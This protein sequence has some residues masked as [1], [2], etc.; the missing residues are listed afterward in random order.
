[1]Y[2]VQ[3]NT[4][5][6]AR[7]VAMAV[8]R[9]AWWRSDRAV[10][11]RRVRRRCG[12]M[13][14]MSD[15]RLLTLARSG[16]RHAAELLIDRHHEPLLAFCRLSLST[17]S[18]AEDVMCDFRSAWFEELCALE[19]E[20]ALR[21]WLYRSVRTSC[22]TRLQ[23]GCPAGTYGTSATLGAD[24]RGSLTKTRETASATLADL[25]Q[26]PEDQRTALLL[27]EIAM[28]RYRE[29]AVAMDTTIATVKY[30]LVHG[31]LALAEASQARALAQPGRSRSRTVRQQQV[32]GG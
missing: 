2:G 23:S 11:Q 16:D 3:D 12:L 9:V 31:R 32:A 1:M 22:L 20:V 24:E 30:L 5:A 17:P 25:R 18:A 10:A 29:I 6:P 19:R 14:L 4:G 13:R 28:L 7:S 21:P 15:D 27:R 8:R 26:L